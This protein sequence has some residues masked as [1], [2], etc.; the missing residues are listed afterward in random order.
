[1]FYTYSEV[2]LMYFDYILRKRSER[3]KES[4]IILEF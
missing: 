1:M 2:D 3:K 4:K